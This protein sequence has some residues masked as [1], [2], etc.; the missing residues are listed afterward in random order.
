M[1]LSDGFAG[2]V[3]RMELH[4][5]LSP[6]FNGAEFANIGPYERLR[7]VVFCSVDPEHRLNAGIVNL[8]LAPRN[9]Q[10]GVDYSF[11]FCILSFILWLTVRL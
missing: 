9:A 2:A 8:K 6:C 7:G 10:G 5:R 4:E 1:T 3:H 11:D